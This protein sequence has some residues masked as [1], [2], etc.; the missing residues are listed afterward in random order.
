MEIGEAF[1]KV[2]VRILP[3]FSIFQ[4]AKVRLQIGASS[5]DGIVYRGL[6]GTLLGMAKHEGV[7]SLYGGISPGLQRQCLFASIRIGLYDP[8]KEFYTDL[9][10]LE[11]KNNGN[12]S[13][14]SNSAS[15]MFIRIASAITTGAIGISV[16][17]VSALKLANRKR[18]SYFRTFFWYFSQQTS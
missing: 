10:H 11:R 14:T 3:K 1:F 6:F 2:L 9:L 5:A 18:W 4:V 7:G 16:A 15:T 12:G 8:V 13:T 17:Q